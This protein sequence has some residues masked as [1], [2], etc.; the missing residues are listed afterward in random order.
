MLVLFCSLVLHQLGLEVIKG[1]DIDDG[2]ESVE[3][4]GGL[5]VFAALAVHANSESVRHVAYT[6]SP[7]LFIEAGVDANVSGT[8]G[9]LGKLLDLLDSPRSPLLE[10]AEDNGQT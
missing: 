1:I 7:N 9:L 3:F 10:S 8:H 6:A 2:N 5:L 4:V